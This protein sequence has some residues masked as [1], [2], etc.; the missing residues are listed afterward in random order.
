[1]PE[2]PKATSSLKAQLSSAQPG[3]STV[4][5]PFTPVLIPGSDPE[6][7]LGLFANELSEVQFLIIFF[8]FFL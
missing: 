5:F 3:L 4:T 1:M 2:L 8:L 7:R 6:F